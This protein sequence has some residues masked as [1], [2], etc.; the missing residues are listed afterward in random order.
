MVMVGWVYIIF[1]YMAKESQ[2][3]IKGRWEGLNFWGFLH[4]KETSISQ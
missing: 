4:I 1:L 3:E 2:R